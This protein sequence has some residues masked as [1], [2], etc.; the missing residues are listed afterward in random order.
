MNCSHCGMENAADAKFCKSCG[1]PLA[2]SEEEKTQTMPA[3]DA[4]EAADSIARENIAPEEEAF[5]DEGR[6]KEN[7]KKIIIGVVAVL[8]AIALIALCVVAFKS[9][10]RTR[11]RKA[12]ES[13][14]EDENYDK[15]YEEYRKLY[16]I[17]Q[18]ESDKED[19][20]AAKQLA[21]DKASLEAADDALNDLA[22]ADALERYVAVKK[23]DNEL[24]EKAEDGI[25]AVVTAA[26]GK[27]RALNGADEFDKAS[28][29][30]SGLLAVAPE[31]GR[32][33]AL[34][35]ETGLGKDKKE[36]EET[37]KKVQAANAE[38]SASK[39]KAN[40]AKSEKRASEASRILYTT[41]RVTAAHANVR[42]G[43]GKG[44]PTLYVLDR[45]ASVYVIDTQSDSV[46]TWCNIG[47]GWISY[48]TL[49]GE[50]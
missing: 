31:N 22:L 41:Q 34:K 46:R 49:N 15:A 27:I 28:E 1:T 8:A 12:A 14:M 30:L 26:E 50:F 5:D 45:G 6:P 10:Q 40:A 4:V 32:L 39:A 7:K 9:T 23:H 38:A 17:T 2:P 18:K 48:R 21:K 29:L 25:S 11:I 42:S 13:A 35:E 44:Y 36:A 24:K 19:A 43:P 3:V 33:V 47:D 16:D 37:A 20:A